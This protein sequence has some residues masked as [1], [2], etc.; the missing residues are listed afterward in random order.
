MSQN[1]KQFPETEYLVLSK[2]GKKKDV[3]KLKNLIKKLI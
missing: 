3:R 1:N 2:K